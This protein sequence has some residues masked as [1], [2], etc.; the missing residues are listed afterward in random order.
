MFASWILQN[1]KHFK[2]YN[3]IIIQFLKR[4]EE[5]LCVNYEFLMVW[6]VELILFI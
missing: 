5:S 3:S 2:R 6:S 4:G 1:Y